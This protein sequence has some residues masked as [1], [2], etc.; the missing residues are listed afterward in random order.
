MRE[1]ENPSDP[2]SSPRMTSWVESLNVQV[3]RRI[4]HRGETRRQDGPAGQNGPISGSFDDHTPHSMAIATS[5]PAVQTI[6]TA[7]IAQSAGRIDRRTR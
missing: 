7:A 6:V 5:A 4:R 1:T 2:T 3:T